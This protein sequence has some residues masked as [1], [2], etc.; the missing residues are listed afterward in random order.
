MEPLLI[1]ENAM[2]FILFVGLS[3][4]ASHAISQTSID[5]IWEGELAVNADTSIIVHFTLTTAADGTRAAVLNAPDQPALTDIAASSVALDADRLSIEVPSI[6]GS[7]EGRFSQGQFEGTWSQQGSSFPLIL[8]PYVAPSLD[9]EDNRRL[10]GSWVGSLKPIP[11]SDFEIAVVMRFEAGESGE[12]NAYFD[13]PD[14]GARD[15][16]MQDLAL[17]GDVFSAS[18]SRIGARFSGDLGADFIDGSITQQGQQMA[19]RLERGEYTSKGLELSAEASTALGGR[20]QGSLETPAGV[21]TL[22][23]RFETSAQGVV[24]GFMDSPDQGAEGIPIT[25]VTYDAGSVVITIGAVN[26]A[27]TAT[28]EEDQLNGNWSQGGASMPLVLDRSPQ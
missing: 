8:S 21:L 23:M 16:T 14:Q 26:G 20:W 28:L 27:F 6:T 7:Y 24:E 25:A 5:G 12:F 15:I 4:I 22:V 2:R 3:F 19:L 13:S 1:L 9:E 11:N 10:T 18:I 17:E